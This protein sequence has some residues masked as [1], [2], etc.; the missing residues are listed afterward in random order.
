M[1][2]T[3]AFAVNVKM[4]HF[5]S[6]LFFFFSFRW[7]FA[8]TC[9]THKKQQQTNPVLISLLVAP[10]P[11]CYP[12]MPSHLKHLWPLLAQPLQPHQPPAA[13]HYS[14]C[15]LV[16]DSREGSRARTPRTPKHPE[17]LEV[18]SSHPASQQNNQTP[19]IYNKSVS[20]SI[21]EKEKEAQSGDGGGGKDVCKVGTK[22][23]KF[24]CLV[25]GRR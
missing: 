18:P 6:W 12:I 16:W 7:H 20:G 19:K 24:L 25:S 3:D 15:P 2:W 14:A 10:L 21:W 11:L 8:D 23:K 4:L 13:G 9:Q 22:E 17:Q 1:Q 5:H